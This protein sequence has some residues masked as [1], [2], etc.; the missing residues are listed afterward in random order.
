MSPRDGVNPWLVSSSV[1]GINGD[2]MA[3][4]PTPHI[5]QLMELSSTAA[6]PTLPQDLEREICEVLL[7][8]ARDM[9]ATISLVA[10][11]FHAWAKHIKFHTVVVRR[12]NDW[13]QRI[14]ECVLPNAEFIRVLVLD[15]PFRDDK[16][17]PA[18]RLAGVRHLAVTWKIWK[19]LAR[20]CGALHLQSL[21]VIWDGV[22]FDVEAAKGKALTLKRLQHPA[23]LKALTVYAP[24]SVEPHRT[25]ADMYFPAT[26]NCTSLAYV[27]Y[28][29]R[30]VVLEPGWAPENFK[31]V[32]SVGLME[33][34][35]NIAAE[36][37]QKKK[38][39]NFSTV[40]LDS[41]EEL[42][43]QWLNKME[44]RDSRLVHP[45]PRILRVDG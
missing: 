19:C 21:Y 20:E 31:G 25:G 7:E 37:E 16:P 36:E 26:T 5:E 13:V 12:H 10:P 32:M 9:Y 8:D 3:C 4:T 1:L 2:Q 29:A 42:L 23:A 33:L 34:P 11:R 44:G 39:P 43:Q 27:T 6:D 28:A 30:R 45:P 41:L 17:C 18:Q 22:S 35:K 24:L 40:Y 38:Y 14:N 15:L